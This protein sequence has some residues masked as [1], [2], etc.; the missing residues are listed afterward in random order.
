MLGPVVP[1]IS[2][3]STLTSCSTHVL[4]TRLRA[5]GWF[6]GNGEQESSPASIEDRLGRPRAA[7]FMQLP[8]TRV[9]H[10]NAPSSVS[11]TRSIIS[12]PSGSV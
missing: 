1:R 3:E 7:A 9:S 4:T 2:P 11:C 12:S 5:R 10:L 6:D 8:T